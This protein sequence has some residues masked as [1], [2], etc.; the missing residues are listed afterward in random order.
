MVAGDCSGENID[1]KENADTSGDASFIFRRAQKRPF[2]RRD[3]VSWS[4]WWHCCL[5]VNRDLGDGMLVVMLQ[6][7]DC[8]KSNEEESIQR[9][10]SVE[11]RK[12]DPS[13]SIALA[14]TLTASRRMEANHGG[15]GTAG[16]TPSSW[17]SSRRGD[18]Y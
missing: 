1:R 15:T 16:E 17:P 6:I 9:K 5:E 4:L 14:A 11:N 2:A 18:T 13:P 10:G 3:S 8:S 7:Q 12:E